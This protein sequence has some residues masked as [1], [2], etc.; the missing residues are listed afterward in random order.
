MK[1]KLKPIKLEV[2]HKD[3]YTYHIHI[4]GA[5]AEYVIPIDWAE[6]IEEPILLGTLCLFWENKNER[7]IV[8][9]YK[10]YDSAGKRHVDHLGRHWKNV[11]PVITE[12]IY[13]WT[14]PK[15]KSVE[16]QTQEQ[17]QTI[18]AGAT[19][20]LRELL[21]RTEGMKII[22][23]EDKQLSDG[24]ELPTAVGRYEALNDVI[25][26]LQEKIK[27]VQDENQTETD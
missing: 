12:D 24:T 5:T 19:A 26:L 10:R 6:E 14:M 4:F 23:A 22:A 27:E 13:R 7:G 20:I 8:S 15:G 9:W 21:E 3:T 1:I 17:I 11:R 18:T 2:S 25:E 16:K